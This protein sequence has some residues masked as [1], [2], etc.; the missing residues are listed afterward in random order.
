MPCRMQWETGL[1]TPGPS[2]C[3]QCTATWT[4]SSS[5]AK[6]R[7]FVGPAPSSGFLLEEGGLHNAESFSSGNKF[8]DRDPV[9]TF[10]PMLS[11]TASGVG[12]RPTALAEGGG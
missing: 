11:T 5:C 4:G 2:P 9:F 6:C 10:S 8:S 7:L 12:E 3:F 1:K